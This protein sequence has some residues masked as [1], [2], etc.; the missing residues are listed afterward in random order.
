MYGIVFLSHKTE[1]AS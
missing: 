1:Y